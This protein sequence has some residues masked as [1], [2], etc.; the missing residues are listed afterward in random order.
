MGGNEDEEVRSIH[1]PSLTLNKTAAPI[2]NVSTF[3]LFDNKKGAELI[4]S[5]ITEN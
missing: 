4:L 5:S 2:W 3:V 1:A